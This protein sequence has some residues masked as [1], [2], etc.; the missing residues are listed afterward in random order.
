MPDGSRA[1]R[2]SRRD[3]GLMTLAAAASA[4]AGCGPSPG[5]PDTPSS[6]ATSSD[7]RPLESS[8]SVAQDQYP[9]SAAFFL[10]QKDLPTPDEFARYDVVVIDNEW[11]GRV[12]PDFFHDLRNRNPG[13]RILAYVNLIDFPIGLGERSQWANR[14]ALWQYE[15][16]TQSSFPNEW[17][18]TTAGGA[19]VSQWPHTQMTN[20]TDGAPRVGG[21]TFADYGAEW[22]VDHV[23]SAGQW[24]G[25]FLD[26]WGDRIWS[27]DYHAWDYRRDGNDTP[28]D[29]IYGLD[30]P[31][32]R[33]INGAETFMRSR[34]PDAILVAN[35][36]RTMRDQHLNGRVWEDF[37]DVSTE[38][39]R[40]QDLQ[41]YLT[42]STDPAVRQPPYAMTI[43]IR[44]APH[45]SAAEYQRAR[46]FLTAT[47][48]GNEL[49]RRTRRRRSG[50]W[51]FG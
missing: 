5:R 42:E 27:A 32:E 48:L 15:T 9:K 46:Y 25:I 47:L 38:S 14:Y 40:G 20:L 21:R 30:H 51:I 35:G 29:D 22:V 45:G 18:A 16:P 7:P 6:S 34:M 41:T 44:G 43:N 49:L 17:M 11:F 28:E 23:W 36:T 3:F 12:G 4:A 2:F 31:W 1:W 39:G 26:V 13:V 50:P 24:D 37:L 33:G 10:A 19:T 8:Y